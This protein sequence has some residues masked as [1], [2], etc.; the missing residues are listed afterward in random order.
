VRA[1]GGA[2]FM[3]RRHATRRQAIPMSYK[4][5]HATWMRQWE[6]KSRPKRSCWF[7]HPSEIFSLFPFLQFFATD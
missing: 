5:C 3:S 6:F 7:V 2:F 1:A 4:G